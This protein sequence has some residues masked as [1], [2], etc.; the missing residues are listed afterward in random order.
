MAA[1]PITIVSS[2]EASPVM[3]PPQPDADLPTSAV[4]T[5]SATV[6]V[7]ATENPTEVP[8]APPTPAPVRLTL[9]IKPT[10]NKKGP[11][12]KVTVADTVISY[13]NPHD[14]FVRRSY[15]HLKESVSPST[16]ELIN[17][18]LDKM[19]GPSDLVGQVME[20]TSKLFES[21]GVTCKIEHK[22]PK[23]TDHGS[24]SPASTMSLKGSLDMP[25]KIIEAIMTHKPEA[26]A[27]AS[28]VIDMGLNIAR[29]VQELKTVLLEEFKTPDEVLKVFSLMHDSL[30]AAKHRFSSPDKDAFLDDPSLKFYIFR[31]G[32]TTVYV[33][34][35]DR[36]WTS[37][38]HHEERRVVWNPRRNKYVNLQKDRPV[39]RA[40]LEHLRSCYVRWTRQRMVGQIPADFED[41]PKNIRRL[42]ASVHIKPQ[43][44]Q[45]Q[46]QQE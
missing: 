46:Q 7:S 22:K 12:S 37:M 41:T 44:Q 32:R 4:D 30:V 20:S 3:D 15:R 17:A 1:V 16:M 10:A 18:F 43:P 25:E 6:D 28:S 5:T 39:T 9:V 19:S 11:K 26:L 34:K 35:N 36:Q 38:L 14:H 23:K 31:E 33:I 29:A 40:E 21:A 42:V 2:G 45:Q 24:A 27:F 13:T 8:P